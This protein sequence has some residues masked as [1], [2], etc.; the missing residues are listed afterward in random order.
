[1][2]VFVHVS[3]CIIPGQV[4]VG[5]EQPQLVQPGFILPLREYWLTDSSGGLVFPVYLSR[6]YPVK[7]REL[8]QPPLT[9][10]TQHSGIRRACSVSN[11]CTLLNNPIFPM[12]QFLH[13][14]LIYSVPV[15]KYSLGVSCCDVWRTVIWLSA[16][17]KWTSVGNFLVELNGN[18]QIAHP[19]VAQVVKQTMSFH[20]DRRDETGK[21]NLKCA[22][23]CSHQ[24][25]KGP[26]SA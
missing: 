7:L 5:V 8:S 24:Q 10:S 12:C 2:Q 23:M 18:T 26:A 25:Q 3:M 13:I 17:F 14:S 9:P 22:A 21:N 16:L 19:R 1:M 20:S 6:D 4:S 11:N 15:R